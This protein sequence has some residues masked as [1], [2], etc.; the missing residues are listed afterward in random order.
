M[1]VSPRF[2]VRIRDGSFVRMTVF[3]GKEMNGLLKVCF[4]GDSF[5]VFS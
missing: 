2:S 1:A 5:G 4:H 3:S